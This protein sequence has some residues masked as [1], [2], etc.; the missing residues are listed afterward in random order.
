MALARVL[1]DAKAGTPVVAFEQGTSDLAHA[2]IRLPD[3]NLLDID[4]V[5]DAAQVARNYDLVDYQPEDFAAQV[6][7]AEGFA[8]WSDPPNYELAR[9]FVGRVTAR[10]TAR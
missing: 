6:D 9:T 10:V 8:K 5:H 4:G 2:L 1:A 7:A 3:G